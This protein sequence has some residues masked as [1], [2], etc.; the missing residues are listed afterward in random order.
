MFNAFEEIWL[1]D[2]EFSAPAGE[3]PAPVCMVA[4]EFRTGRI[5]RIWQDEL[6]R[7]E[8]P[9]FRMEPDVLYVAYYASAELG[10]HLAPG[11]TMPARILDLCIEFQNQTNGLEVEAGRSLLGALLH[12]GLPCVEVEHK[13]SM[14]TLALRGGA[15]TDRE[16]LD[17]LDYCQS[18]VDA[19]EGLLEQMAPAIDLP[20]ALLRGRYMAAAARMEWA[21]IPLDTVTSQALKSRWQSVQDRLIAEVDRDFRVYDGRTFKAARFAGYL[22]EAGVAWPT[23]DRG[24]LKLDNDT[25]KMMSSIYPALVPL[26]Q[27]RRSLSTLKNSQLA[28]GGDSRNRCLLSAFASK[29][30]RNQPSSSK[31]IFGLPAWTRSLIQPGPGRAVAYIDYSQQEFGIAAALSGDETMMAAYRTGDP[32]L[33]FAV[34][35]GAAPPPGATKAS[36]G[37]IRRRFKQT[38]L[39]V[40][41]RMGE[42]SLARTL[43]ES[44]AHARELLRLY[45]GTYRR[46]WEWSDAVVDAAMLRN[47]I[48]TVFGWTLHVRAGVNPRTLVTS[49]C[50][51]TGRKCSGSRAAC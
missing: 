5:V 25:F 50:R 48:R 26:Q 18:D 49:R 17:L 27:L 8:G 45:R 28:V 51:R 23:T 42:D 9:P 38:A 30:G 14:R 44:P 47:H 19:L 7:I 29:T 12:Y 13:E 24:N 37:H 41:Y 39:A 33:A 11:W 6:A 16:Q 15:Y 32:Y 10:C 43:G 46:Y 22:A 21:G 20:R 2:F 31:F 1:V 4:R 36:H 34:Q 40:Q 35:A 3:R